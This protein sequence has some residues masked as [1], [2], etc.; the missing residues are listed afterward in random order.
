M[1]RLT[2]LAK[3]MRTRADN[4]RDRGMYLHFIRAAARY[5]RWAMLAE[6]LEREARRERQCSAE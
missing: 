3:Y 6:K 1:C 5:D 2:Q 4:S